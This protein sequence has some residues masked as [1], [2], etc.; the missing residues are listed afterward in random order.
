MVVMDFGPLT[1]LAWKRNSLLTETK[2]SK[3]IAHKASEI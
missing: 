1:R 3:Y 2:V